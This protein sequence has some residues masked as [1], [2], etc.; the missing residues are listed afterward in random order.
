MRSFNN[1]SRMTHHR[2]FTLIELL[3]VI[4]IIGVLIGLL[5]PA[6]QQVRES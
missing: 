2:A 4:A 3:V 1:D 6:V 5:L